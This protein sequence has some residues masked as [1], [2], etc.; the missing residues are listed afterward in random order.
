MKK[1]LLTV[2][3]DLSTTLAPY[4]E[5]TTTTPAP[6]P[7]PVPAPTPGLLAQRGVNLAGG[8][9][10][11]NTWSITTGPVDGT[12][13]KFIS[14]ADVTKLIA[15]G[16]NTFRLLFTWEALQ[17][18]PMGDLGAGANNYA[19]YASNLWGLMDGILASGATVILDIHGDR[20]A[21]FAAYRDTVIGKQYLTYD[22]GT[23][24]A[25]LWGRIATKY[26]SNS[27]VQFGVTNEPH[28]IPAATWYAAAQKVVTAIRAAGNTSRIWMPGVD[29]ESAVTWPTYNA[30]Y[31]NLVDPA[32][33]L[34]AQAHMYVD[35]SGGGG[36]S[37]IV[38]KTIGSFRLAAV[39]SWA[40][41]KGIKLFLG[42]IGMAA[43][44]PLA[45]DTWADLMSFMLANQ[46]VWAGF[47]F[48]A[49]GPSDWWGG[50]QFYCG[51]NSAQ[52]ALIQSSLK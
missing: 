25:N 52:L 48:W 38:S 16:C 6:V 15:A 35:A 9:T 45:K 13:Y 33:N 29:W 19:T 40:R 46:D 34:G 28:D 20:D 23:M 1:Y 18:V 37:D 24:L 41:G 3:D 31:W 43:S 26:K 11:W 8:G 47:T 22:V 51:P 50:Y 10:A 7:T 4:V 42:E 27:R 17:S 21:G 36:G 49:A 32:N 12:H 39:T 30:P 14:I 5:P 44:N 2:L